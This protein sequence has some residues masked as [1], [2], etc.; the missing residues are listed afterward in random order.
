[1]PQPTPTGQDMNHTVSWEQKVHL[2]CTQ[3]NLNSL[4]CTCNP[5]YFVDY[6]VIKRIYVFGFLIPKFCL[7]LIAMGRDCRGRLRKSHYVSLLKTPQLADLKTPKES[8][9]TPF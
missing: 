6:S 4:T 7:E 3:Q 1:M 8:I 9:I 2:D 5:I